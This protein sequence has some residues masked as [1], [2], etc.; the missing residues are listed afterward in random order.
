VPNKPTRRLT[1]LLTQSDRQSPSWK[2]SAVKRDSQTTQWT[3]L[4]TCNRRWTSQWSTPEVSSWRIKRP[5]WTWSS[6]K[7]IESSGFIRTAF[8]ALMPVSAFRR[9][10][11]VTT[12]NKATSTRS[13]ITCQILTT[14]SPSRSWTAQQCTSSILSL[15][16]AS[17]RLVSK[18]QENSAAVQ[19]SPRCTNPWQKCC[20]RKITSRHRSTWRTKKAR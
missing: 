10:S 4:M 16:S 12:P 15:L 9:Q 1:N 13:Q 20:V 14:G 17:A 18:N 8:S 11:R 6:T 7:S 3:T 19:A 2:H 5:F